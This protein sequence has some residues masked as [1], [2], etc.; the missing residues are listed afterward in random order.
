L[1][2]NRTGNW[3]SLQKEM[4]LGFAIALILISSTMVTTFANN[5]VVSA[6]GSSAPNYV[7]GNVSNTNLTAAKA[8]EMEG[9]V[10]N[11]TETLAEKSNGNLT[12]M[13]ML[14]LDDLVKR[15]I[16]N[17]KE[18]QELLSFSFVSNEIKP[19]SNFTLVKKDISSRIEKLATNS[20]NPVMILLKDGLKRTA[21][22]CIPIIGIN[23]KVCLPFYRSNATNIVNNMTNATSGLPSIMVSKNFASDLIRAE[24]CY[25][26]A[27]VLYGGLGALEALYLCT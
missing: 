25:L 8:L 2:N 12:K 17:E 22:P 27:M 11:Y 16:I 14:L 19:T 18:K 13:N 10:V 20:S 3:T 5:F 7:L 6:S 24:G 9:K 4:G 1:D 26:T 15:N 21:L 23:G